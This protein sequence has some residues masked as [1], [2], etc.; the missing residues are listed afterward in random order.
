MALRICICAMRVPS[1]EANLETTRLVQST[2][3][4]VGAKNDTITAK[5]INAN[6]S[7]A[8]FTFGRLKFISN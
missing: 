1:G 2:W 4:R 6:T 7:P 5:S 3:I 8:S